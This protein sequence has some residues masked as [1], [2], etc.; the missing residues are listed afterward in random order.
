MSVV[1]N[2]LT[3][4]HCPTCHVHYAVPQAMMER[5]QRDGGNW[6]CPNG[7][8]LVFKAPEI[9]GIRAERDRLKQAMAQKDDELA[10]ARRV[11]ERRGEDLEHERRRVSAAK[12]QV[13]RLKNRASAGV[14][15]CCNRTFVDLQRHM[16]TKHPAFK[17]E[18]QAA[19]NVVKLK[20]A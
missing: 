1:A 2:D 20:T 13:T 4:K 9:D 17:D 11:A 14:C 10:Q 8:S 5:K 7:H 6:Y 19:D 15:P 12:G 3:D 16:S 18:P